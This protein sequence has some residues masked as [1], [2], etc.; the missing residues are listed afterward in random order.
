MSSKKAGN[1]PSFNRPSLPD[2][3][4]RSCRLVVGPETAIRALSV[5]L[6]QLRLSFPASTS[7][8]DLPPFLPPVLAALGEREAL[9]SVGRCIPLSAIVMPGL[10]NVDAARQP[11][12]SSILTASTSLAV[13]I[14]SRNIFSQYLAASIG[15]PLIAHR[16]F[17][18]W[19]LRPLRSSSWPWQPNPT[20]YQSGEIGTCV[21]CTPEKDAKLHGDR[22]APWR[23]ALR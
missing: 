17:L 11:K 19:R 1:G 2:I 20:R 23:Q 7:L 8:R 15:L 6:T 22:S 10:P 21:G 14:S 16:H 4:P 3:W 9:A 13:G 5:A 12:T 18:T